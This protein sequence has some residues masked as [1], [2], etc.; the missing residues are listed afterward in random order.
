MDSQNIIYM[1]NSISKGS[2]Y[3]IFCECTINTNTNYLDKPKNKLKVQYLIRTKL[4]FVCL[5]F[6]NV[7]V[8]VCKPYYVVSSGFCIVACVAEVSVQ[9]SYALNYTN[10]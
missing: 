10:F 6:W 7:G 1:T 9:H 3:T 8:I 5:P 4:V 2:L